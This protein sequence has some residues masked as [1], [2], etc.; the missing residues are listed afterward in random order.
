MQK[1]LGILGLCAV[2]AGCGILPKETQDAPPVQ[3]VADGQMRPQSRPETLDT[4]ARRPPPT[5]R[6]VE[7][8][9]TTTRDE[10]EAAASAPVSAERALGS[11][12]VSLGDPTRPGF[13]VET[14]LVSA[15][16]KGRVVNPDTGQSAQVDLLPA[17][18]TGSRMSLAAMRLIGVP[19]TGLA[20]V[21]LFSGG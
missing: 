2:L 18:G 14:S 19:L 8:F 17:D 7:E 6:T 16:G 12:I 13:W 4:S 21:T 3:A 11:T 5:A 1:K 15:P 20:E 9:D 10:R